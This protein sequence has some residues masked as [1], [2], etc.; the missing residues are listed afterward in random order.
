MNSEQVFTIQLTLNDLFVLDKAIQELPFKI[1][2]PLVKKIN[3]QVS[4]QQLPT[5]IT[6]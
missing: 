2:V 5:P 4:A 3:E 6:E 1:A